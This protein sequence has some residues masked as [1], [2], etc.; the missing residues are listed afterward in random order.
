MGMARKKQMDKLLVLNKLRWPTRWTAKTTILLLTLLIVLFP[1]PSLL[2]RHVAH[3]RDPGAL[4]DPDAPELRPLLEELRPLMTSDLSPP[5]ALRTV[6]RF[7]YEKLP[8][9]HDWETWGTADY[10]PTLREALTMGR[11]DCDGRAVLAASLLCNLG[12]KAELV[13]DFA[14]VWV[15]TDKGETMGPGRK[16][17][18]VVTKEGVQVRRGALALMAKSMI[19]G[20]AVFPLHRDLI[21]LVVLWLLMLRP[22]G[23]RMCA[24]FSL[25]LLI[26]GLLFVR[27]GSADWWRPVLWVQWVGAANLGLALGLLIL[28]ARHN[29][30]QAQVRTT[31]ARDRGCSSES[32]RAG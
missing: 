23:G 3:W 24:I 28:W 15:K 4:V 20:I 12:F 29:A 2:R 6:E 21:V 5:K 8:Y 10:L 19:Y 1:H 30:R 25:A 31:R 13:S 11:E 16:K 17:V 22:G 14:H 18:L 27:I 7:V 9:A 32:S 26:N